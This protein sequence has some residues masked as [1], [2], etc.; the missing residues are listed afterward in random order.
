MSTLIRIF[1]KPVRTTTLA[2]GLK[3]VELR[4]GRIITE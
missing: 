1:R 4:N 2:T 3:I